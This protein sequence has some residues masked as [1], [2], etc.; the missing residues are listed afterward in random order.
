MLR[1]ELA[2]RGDP[3]EENARVVVVLAAGGDGRRDKR[4][5]YGLDHEV[6]V[7]SV[8]DWRHGVTE[9]LRK[10]DAPDGPVIES[11]GAPAACRPRWRRRT[12]IVELYPPAEANVDAEAMAIVRA[13]NA[14]TR[15]RPRTIWLRNSAHRPASR[16]T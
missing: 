8:D 13:P 16:S 12:A 4:G 1:E 5:A 15:P 3:T 9:L 6:R 11:R 2:S 10:P 7:L 14:E